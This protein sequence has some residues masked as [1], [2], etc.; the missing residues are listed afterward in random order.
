M[1]FDGKCMH[2]GGIIL[3]EGLNH[4]VCKTHFKRYYHKSKRE[5]Q[6]PNDV[7]HIESKIWHK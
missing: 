3:V 7:T 1:S 6:I 4:R 5:G 2:W